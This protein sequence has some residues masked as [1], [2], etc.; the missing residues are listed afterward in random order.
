MAEI[1]NVVLVGAGA[2]KA[3]EAIVVTIART[4]KAFAQYLPIK[5]DTEEQGELW[6]MRVMGEETAKSQ[7]L[8]SPKQFNKGLAIPQFGDH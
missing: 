5:E 1:A 3:A 7:F 6:D 8:P 2:A 4:K